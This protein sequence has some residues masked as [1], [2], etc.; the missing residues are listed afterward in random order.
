MKQEYDKYVAEDHQV[1]SILYEKMMKILPDYA[2]KAYIEGIEKVGF[3]PNRIPEFSLSNENLKAITGWMIYVVPGL[4]D[5]KPFFEHL[6]NRE[7]PAST[8][9]RKMSQLEYLEEP[10][11]FH[12]VFGHVPLLANEHFA[13]FLSKLAEIALEHIEDEWAV[14]ILSRLYWYTIEFGLIREDG[15]LKVYGA[16]ILSS[17]GETVYSIDSD[18]PVRHEYNVRQIFSTPYIKDKFQEQY[19]V[20]DSYEQLYNSIPEIRA[21]LKTELSSKAAV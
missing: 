13:N 6:S 17:S 16:G 8:W 1:W 9:L 21:V 15:K 12:D 11:M 2:T 14:E 3:E 19:F 18:I 5:N 4:I 7:F 10:D 20:I